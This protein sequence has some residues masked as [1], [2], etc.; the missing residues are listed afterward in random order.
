MLRRLARPLSL[1]WL[2][3][4]AV[5]FAPALAV[6]VW[7]LGGASEWDG[8]M[9]EPEPIPAT[10]QLLPALAAALIALVGSLVDERRVFVWWWIAAISAW[11]GTWL[12][13]FVLANFMAS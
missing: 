2:L 12:V 6:F 8:R 1:L 13:M 7:N 4:A 5:A 10:V 9:V 3:A 11:V